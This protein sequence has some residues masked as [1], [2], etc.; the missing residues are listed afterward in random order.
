M[1]ILLQE[2]LLDNSQISILRKNFRSY[3]KKKSR[4]NGLVESDHSDTVDGSEITRPP[5][6]DVYIYINPVKSLD[7]TTFPSSGEL[8]PDF[9]QTS[10]VPTLFFATTNLHLLGPKNFPKTA[11]RGSDLVA[12]RDSPVMFMGSAC[13]K[14][15]MGPMK[16]GCLD[17]FSFIVGSIHP[18]GF[19]ESKFWLDFCSIFLFSWICPLIGFG[20]KIFSKSCNQSSLQLLVLV[21][22]QH[23]NT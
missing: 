12:W 20:A 23:C 5:T 21:V 22:L 19:H 2:S 9:F 4:S 16:N 6:W 17:V 7:K 14:G 3:Q 15:S 8:I 18:L 13:F 1:S 11:G 10:T